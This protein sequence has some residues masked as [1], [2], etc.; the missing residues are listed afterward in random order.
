MTMR[1]SIVPVLVL[2]LALAGT[3]PAPAAAATEASPPPATFDAANRLYEQQ[4]YAEA[5]RAYEALLTNRPAAAVWFNLGNARL[6]SG[7][8]G[9]AIAAY[10]HALRLEPRARDAAANLVTA[11]GRAGQPAP[12]AEF[13]QRWLSPDEWA[14]ALLAAVVAWLGLQAARE[15]LPALRR[16]TAAL[17][18]TLGALAGLLALG[19]FVVGVSLRGERAVVVA[20]EAAVRFGPVEESQAAFTLADGAEVRVL[21]RRPGWA[22]VRDGAGRTGWMAEAAVMAAP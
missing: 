20:R 13:L 12:P 7:E 22:Q 21:A 8:V 2:L 18:W 1:P 16:R 4:Q 5:A 3:P 17:V 6:Q 9:R 14:F 11:R 10:R 15:L 19:A